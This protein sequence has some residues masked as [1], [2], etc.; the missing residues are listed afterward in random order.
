M[1]ILYT[2]D[3]KM[4]VLRPFL[5]AFPFV[6][7]WSVVTVEIYSHVVEPSARWLEQGNIRQLTLREVDRACLV[8]LAFT[9]KPMLLPVV[10]GSVA[11]CRALVFLQFLAAGGRFL[12][13]VHPT[14]LIMCW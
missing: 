1:H 8:R 2:P 10:A 9:H 3:K 5:K 12:T 6:C 7:V 13:I 11:V 4:E 14:L